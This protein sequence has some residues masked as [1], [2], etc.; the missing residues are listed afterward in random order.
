MRTLSALITFAAVLTVATAAQAQRDDNWVTMQ[1]DVEAGAPAVTFNLTC[2]DAECWKSDLWIRG[3]DMNDT[4]WFN[5]V[6]SMPQVLVQVRDPATD[7]VVATQVLVCGLENGFPCTSPAG[8]H[9]VVQILVSMG[10]GDD[11][12][13]SFDPTTYSYDHPSGRIDSWLMVWGD[14]GDDVIENVGCAWGGAGEDTLTAPDRPSYLDGGPGAD[15][16]VGGSDRDWLLGGTGNDALYGYGG[17][18]RL[19]GGDGVDVMLGGDGK[20]HMYGGAGNDLMG[21]DGGDDVLEGNGD[22]DQLVGGPG[23]DVL[24][25]GNGTDLLKGDGGNDDLYGNEGPDHLEGGDGDDDLYG[26][27][28]GD[29]MLGGNGDDDLNGGSGKDVADGGPGSDSCTAEKK[30]SC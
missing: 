16:V 5:V 7:R 28:G 19:E 21:G 12:F 18:D 29:T 15:T 30:S 26:N 23:N 14:G 13:Y 25:G 4:V 9:A 6:D 24:R 2:L 20:D 22:D 3:T 8:P 1:G 27:D 17:D 10:E 11:T